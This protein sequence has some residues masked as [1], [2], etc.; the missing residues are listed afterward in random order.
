M[1]IAVTDGLGYRHKIRPNIKGKP[2]TGRKS[3]YRH[4]RI[5]QPENVG[6]NNKQL[7]QGGKSVE[8][9]KHSLLKYRTACPWCPECG[10][11]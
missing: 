3:S 10:T 9:L 2:T 8:Q 4:I 7:A 5:E 6:K 1:C 11:A